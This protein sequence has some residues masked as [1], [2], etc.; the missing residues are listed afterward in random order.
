MSCFSLLLKILGLSL[1]KNTL[2]SE[3]A[4]KMVYFQKKIV[5]LNP[6]WGREFDTERRSYAKFALIGPIFKIL[7]S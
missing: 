6:F 3:Y 7:N 5:I 1:E 4:P 2:F